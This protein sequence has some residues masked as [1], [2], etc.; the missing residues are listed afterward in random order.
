MEALL[1]VEEKQ[2]E[3]SSSGEFLPSEETKQVQCSWNQRMVT[4]SSSAS[5]QHIALSFRVPNTE[6]NI[7]FR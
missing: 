6:A 3:L 2:S 1:D 7:G 5:R 4:H